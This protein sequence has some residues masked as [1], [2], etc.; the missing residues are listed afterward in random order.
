[1]D[2]ELTEFNNTLNLN[3]LSSSTSGRIYPVQKVW[4]VGLDINF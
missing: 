4:A 2:P 1:M 3:Q